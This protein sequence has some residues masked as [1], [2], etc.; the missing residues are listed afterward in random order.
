MNSINKIIEIGINKIRNIFYE[1]NIRI[2]ISK[3][4]EVKC[5]LCG[6]TFIT[7]E[8]SEGTCFR[9]GSNKNLRRVK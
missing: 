1:S 7:D 4:I 8:S 9:C 6:Q 3:N 2:P 5:C